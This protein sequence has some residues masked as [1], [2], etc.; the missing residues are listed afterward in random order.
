MK[1]LAI[2]QS[3]YI[4]WKGYFDLI[5]AVDEFVLYDDM[6]YT[7]R[8]W[9]NRNKI[10]TPRGAEWLTI[11]VEV[12]GKYFQKINETRVNDSDWHRAHWSSIQHNYARAPH[13]AEQREWLRELYEGCGESLLS[14]INFRFIRAICER[15]DIRTRVTWSSDYTLVE[16][17]NERLIHLCRQVGADMY[18]SGPSAKGYMD[19]EAFNRA[20]V[21]VKFANYSAYAEYPQLHPPFDH[22]VSI[23]DLLLNTGDHA[24]NYMISFDTAKLKNFLADA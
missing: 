9:R 12:K 16:D 3:N 20:G 15:L 24:K 7:R 14:Q 19:I 5:N 17:R 4:P 8:D 22:Y 1:R 23:L 21:Q 13:F 11:P 10:K 6:Q 2:V 18:V